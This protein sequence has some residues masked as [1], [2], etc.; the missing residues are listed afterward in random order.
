MQDTTPKNDEN[1]LSQHASSWA[2]G[3]W[4]STRLAPKGKSDHVAESIRCVGG[5]RRRACRRRTRW[6]PVGMTG[7]MNE[8]TGNGRAE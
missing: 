5:A 2:C 6:E 3:I 7:G 4:P 1:R 8:T